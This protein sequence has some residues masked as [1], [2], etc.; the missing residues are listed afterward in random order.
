MEIYYCNKCKTDVKIPLLKEELK[1]EL[2]ALLENKKPLLAIKLIKENSNLG[3]FDSKVL[4]DHFD[5]EKGKCNRCNFDRLEG[6]ELYCNKCKAF[7]LNWSSTIID[8]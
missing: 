5:K 7:N 4:I 1:N 8:I 3:L 6:I 2:V